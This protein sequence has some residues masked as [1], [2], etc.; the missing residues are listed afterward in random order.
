MQLEGHEIKN[1]LKLSRVLRE[2]KFTHAKEVAKN[3]LDDPTF[4]KKYGKVML[5]RY[6]ELGGIAT[7]IKKKASP[8]VASRHSA[9]EKDQ[10][11]TSKD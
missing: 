9:W 5:K 7:P 3:K 4:T 6:L 10:K 11:E 8:Q 1:T 2:F